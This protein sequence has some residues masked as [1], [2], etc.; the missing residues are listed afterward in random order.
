MIW[1]CLALLQHEVTSYFASSSTSEL[2]P[3]ELNIEKLQT[4]PTGLT[5]EGCIP[6]SCFCSGAPE[7][8]TLTYQAKWD[9]A[10][11][12]TPDSSPVIT[13]EHVCCEE[14]LQSVGAFSTEIQRNVSWWRRKRFL[15]SAGEQTWCRIETCWS[16]AEFR[17][18]IFYLKSSRSKTHVK[19][20]SSSSCCDVTMIM[21]TRGQQSSEGQKLSDPVRTSDFSLMNFE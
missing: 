6:F 5:N 17:W 20:G 9:G 19:V 10:I 21:N 3:S 1:K 4:C 7:G 11:L 12:K 16:S 13:S 2:Y 14:G 15:F 8:T 18:R